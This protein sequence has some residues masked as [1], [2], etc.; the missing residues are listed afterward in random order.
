MYCESCGTKTDGNYCSEC[1]KK[2][3]EG[4]ISQ[5]QATIGLIILIPIII[6]LIIIL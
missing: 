3:D 6:A 4:P 5:R 1:G 2:V